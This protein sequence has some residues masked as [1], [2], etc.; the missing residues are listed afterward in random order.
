MGSLSGDAAAGTGTIATGT[1]S[2][3]LKVGVLESDQGILGIP[4]R[5]TATLT[6]PPDANFDLFLYVDESGLPTARACGPTPQEASTNAS[7]TDTVTHSW[8]ESTIANNL[9]DSRIVS[10]EV[11]HVSGACAGAGWSLTV[12]GD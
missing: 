9:D 5:V 11:R 1:I 4:L 12:K 6:S 3:W 8:G 2:T 7:G 10:I